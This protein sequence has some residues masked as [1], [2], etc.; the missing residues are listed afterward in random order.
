MDREQFDYKN[1]PKLNDETNNELALVH[2]Y[3]NFLRT[4]YKEVSAEL[5]EVKAENAKLGL[6]NEKR[7]NAI[8][9]ELKLQRETLRNIDKTL[10]KIETNTDRTKTILFQLLVGG[11][12]TALITFG[13]KF[14]TI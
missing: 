6:E 10:G 14:V 9:T 8:E 4:L 3:I 12:I 5:E 2:R 13:M 7:F 11:A 1:N